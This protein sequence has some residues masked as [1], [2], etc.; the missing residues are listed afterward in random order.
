MG[1][2]SLC[3]KLGT[4]IEAGRLLPHRHCPS[5]NPCGHR[6]P[7]GTVCC[8]ENL[9][10]DETG[11]HWNA[12]GDALVGRVIAKARNVKR[13]GCCFDHCP[14]PIAL[15]ELPRRHEGDRLDSWSVGDLQYD[16]YLAN[17]GTGFVADVCRVRSL[18]ERRTFVPMAPGVVATV[19]ASD[20]SVREVDTD[21]PAV[22]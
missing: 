21:L 22:R 5:W 19:V 6:D 14:S 10:T 13:G 15:I 12:A 8:G 9:T 18:V 1:T 4:P 17:T 7:K 11:T 16:L 3:V 20:P 2:R